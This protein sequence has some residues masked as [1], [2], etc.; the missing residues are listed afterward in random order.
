MTGQR[1]QTVRIIPSL[2]VVT[3]QQGCG[4]TGVRVHPLAWGNYFSY[5]SRV[6]GYRGSSP[7]LGELVSV[8][9]SSHL[10]LGVIPLLG[11]IA[12][13]DGSFQ[14]QD[15]VHP[16]AWENYQRLN[17]CFHGA[18]GW[19]PRLGELQPLADAAFDSPGLIPSVWGTAMSPCGLGV[20]A[21]DHPL[22]WWNFWP[23]ASRHSIP[24]GSSPRVG[25]LLGPSPDNLASRIIPFRGGSLACLFSP[26]IRHWGPAGGGAGP[27]GTWLHHGCQVCLGVLG[28]SGLGVVTVWAVGD[29]E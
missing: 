5:R 19:F 11:G 7:R 15:G 3:A 12:Y 27:W 17:V 16:L 2:G 25:E 10:T 1:G 8:V 6:A 24:P 14:V 29:G 18:L 9:V 4:C 22:A 26:F 20:A 21:P 13:R 23:S 28:P